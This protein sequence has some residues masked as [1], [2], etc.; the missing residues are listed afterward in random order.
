M[1]AKAIDMCAVD[2]VVNFMYVPSSVSHC[3]A[4]GR[5]SYLE[6]FLAGRKIHVLYDHEHCLAALVANCYL[7]ACASPQEVMV[8]NRQA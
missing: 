2:S 5:K 1:D 4:Y 3:K 8:S 6:F 7:R